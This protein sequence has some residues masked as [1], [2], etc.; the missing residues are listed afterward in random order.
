MN[1]VIS[2]SGFNVYIKQKIW[3]S[4]TEY[5][6]AMILNKWDKIK[7]NKPYFFTVIHIRNVLLL[8]TVNKYTTQPGNDVK[9]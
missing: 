7:I 1:T 9:L 4:A 2:W 3:K 6:Y 8:Q 5:V